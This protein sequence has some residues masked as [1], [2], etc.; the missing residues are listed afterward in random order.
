MALNEIET[1]LKKSKL[2][3][4]K[5]LLLIEIRQS[6]YNQ[7]PPAVYNI[8]NQLFLVLRFNGKFRYIRKNESQTLSFGFKTRSDCSPWDIEPLNNKILL[9]VF[10]IVV[11]LSSQ[12][13]NRSML[14]K[15][16]TTVSVLL[17]SLLQNCLLSVCYKT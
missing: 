9:A 15:S 11:K 14:S 1:V 5:L 8:K 3:N 12:N 7:L 2:L 16:L 6:V 17:P 10:E 4:R 13:Y